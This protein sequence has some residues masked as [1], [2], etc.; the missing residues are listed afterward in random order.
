MKLYIN[1]LIWIS[2]IAFGVISCSDSPEAI[3][4][5]IQEGKTKMEF[6][7]SYPDGTKVTETSFEK[8]DMVG[9]F[10]SEFDK[11]LEISGNVI[12]NE[13][14]KFDGSSWN[15]SRTLYWNDGFFNVYAYYPYMNDITSIT[16]LNFEV[17]ADQRSSSNGMSSYEASDL[18][19]A[20]INGVQGSANPLSMQFKHIM[21]KVTI[22]LIKGE[23]Y[24][25]DI[26]ES[27]EVTI[28]NTVTKATVDLRSGVATR[29]IYGKKNTIIAKQT[30][31]SGYTAIV[32]PQRVDNMA[33]LVEVVMD[34]VSYLFESRIVFKSG[35]NHI[36]NLVINDNPEKV[37]IEIG[38][39]INNW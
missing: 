20:N 23:D 36:L 21:S 39:E 10:V 6:S 19:F 38:G 24:E 22:R 31:A 33:P 15:P 3:G 37:K 11:K 14:L 17:A 2:V 9:V 7:F 8:D 35:I 27:A 18:L 1:Q 30:S 12:N 26:P 28:L 25:G 34:G 13:R 16:D 29:D 5:E 32:V 4:I